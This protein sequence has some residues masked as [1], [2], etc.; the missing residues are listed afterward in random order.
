[1]P[2][3]LVTVVIPAR[4]EER[5]LAP[6]LESV[7]SQDF[8]NLQ[9][10]VVE[11]GSI[12]GT[13]DIASR[14]A[15]E[16]PRVEV[17]RNPKGGI[18]KSLNVALKAARGTWLVRVDAHSTIPSHYVRRAVDRLKSGHWAGVGGR[19]EGVGLT[20]AG[21]AIA[22]AMSSPFG[23][24]GSLYHYGKRAQEVDHI[25]FGAYRTALVRELGGWDERL[26]TANED[27]EF[28]YRMRRSGHRLLFD[29]DLR[30][31]WYCR[32]SVPDLFH[33]YRRYGHGKAAVTRLHPRSVR[34]RH[35][36]P[37]VL[38]LY[39]AGTGLLALRSPRLATLGLLPYISGV[40][41][42]TATTSRLMENRTGIAH[43]PTVFPAMHIG[44]GLGF[45]EGLAEI[46]MNGRQRRT[47]AIE[48]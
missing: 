35:L 9:V 47:S 28:D 31:A 39:L 1:M 45:W 34:P 30:I 41:L 8:A 25:P 24:G 11:G 7:L 21:R 32:Q 33:Q 14:F 12:D 4:N 18:P 22:A 23:V 13:A 40:L 27:F 43:L 36:L 5:F 38:V 19:K 2:E 16:D 10:I 15:A 48:G 42:A 46:A 29:P 26:Q 17:R 6:C 37:P 44:Y 20:H 3:D